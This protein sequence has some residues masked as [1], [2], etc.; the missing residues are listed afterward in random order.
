MFIN[1]SQH[2]KERKNKHVDNFM[3]RRTVQEI[4]NFD[5]EGDAGGKR[6]SFREYECVSQYHMYFLSIKWTL[7]VA[8]EVGSGVIKY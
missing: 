3:I 7:M 5:P 4:L 6:L 1:L 8:L 2:E